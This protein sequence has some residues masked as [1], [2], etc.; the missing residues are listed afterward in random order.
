MILH[1]GFFPGFDQKKLFYRF[2]D[3]GEAS[4]LLVILH[5][6]G[7]HSG[8]YEKFFRHLQNENL[9]LAVYDFR[10]HGQSEGP[11]V[12][13]DS[14][15]D[16]LEDVSSFTAFLTNQFGK[17]AKTFFLAHSVGGLVA[18]HWSLRHLKDL[19]GLILSSPCLGLSL[20]KFLVQFNR[21]MNQIAP[22]FLYQNPVYPP[23]LS[24]DP[25]EVALYKED[26]WI[27]R[28][29]S[30]RLLHE[31]L[32]YASR[33]D[34]V[35]QFQFPFPVHVLMAD[36]EKVVDSNRTR[37][38]YEKVVAPAKRMQVF[39]GFYH[40]IFNERGQEEAFRAL[41]VSLDSMRNR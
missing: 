12:D 2:W 20:P 17:K 37:A 8:R 9:S 32:S 6:H 14:F 41:K 31:M 28:K 10:G 7:E 34:V 18:I 3:Q 35:D 11:S 38:F 36:L 4:D 16:Y 22:R 13:I 25:E 29:M 1:Q 15:E 27:Q 24:H 40:E 21:F 26:K 23:H 19:D 39:S 30:V 33:L 5:G